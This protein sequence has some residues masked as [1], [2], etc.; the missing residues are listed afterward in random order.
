MFGEAHALWQSNARRSMS[1]AWAASG[2]VTQRSR[3]CPRVVVG[4]TTSWDWMRASSLRTVRGELPSRVEAHI[5]VC[6]LAFVLW[7]TLEM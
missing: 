4:N 3:I 2:W 6:F 5:L 7:K 1:A